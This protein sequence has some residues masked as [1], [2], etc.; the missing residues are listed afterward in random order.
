MTDLTAALQRILGSA[1]NFEFRI[2]SAGILT[3]DLYNNTSGHSATTALS[4][5][6][7]YHVVCTGLESA[8]TSTTEI[9]INGVS[10]GTT[11]VA[12]STV[13][14]AILTIA[15][16]TGA[17]NNSDVIL[18]DIRIYNR[19]LSTSEIETIYAARGV[20]GIVEGLLVRLQ[21]EEDAPGQAAP[22]GSGG[23]IDSAEDPGHGDFD[24]HFS[25]TYA[26]GVVRTR[27]KTA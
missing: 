2:S 7:W 14:A 4:V 23:V 5:D 27:R 24:Q 6:T 16:R 10:E 3:N 15:N 9:F 17:S 19:V 12:S 21:F 13:A 22:A 8:G 26:D 25:P 11:D 1:T 20:D 18:D